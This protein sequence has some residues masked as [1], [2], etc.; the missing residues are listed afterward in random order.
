MNSVSV[1]VSFAQHLFFH[2]QRTVTGLWQRADHSTPSALP[3]S[4]FSL[5]LLLWQIFSQHSS[6]PKEITL[7]AGEMQPHRLEE[8]TN[9]EPAFAKLQN[10]LTTTMT[11]YDPP[12]HLPVCCSLEMYSIYLK[13]KLQRDHGE[14]IQIE[15]F[16]SLVHF[17]M[18]A[19][20]WCRPGPKVPFGSPT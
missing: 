12:R 20:A 4:I 3:G 10:D 8:K 5:C 15:I 14:E 17:L 13:N 6:S 16:H 2:S 7:G 19:T 18:A 11:K 9:Q 1:Q